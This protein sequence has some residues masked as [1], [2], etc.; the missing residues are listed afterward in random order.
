MQLQKSQYDSTDY[1]GKKSGKVSLFLALLKMD[2]AIYF[3]AL[4]LTKIKHT[5]IYKI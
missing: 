5:C 1:F 4:S 3:F 2:S